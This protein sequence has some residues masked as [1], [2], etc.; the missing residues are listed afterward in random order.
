MFLS[1]EFGDG[2]LLRDEKLIDVYTP[3]ISGDIDET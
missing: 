1:T 3:L 2:E